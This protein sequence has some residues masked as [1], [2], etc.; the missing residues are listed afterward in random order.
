M[1]GIS[2]RRW[3]PALAFPLLTLW[4]CRGPGARAAAP[5][6]PE[7]S[8]L[9]GDLVAEVDGSPVTRGVLDQRVKNRLA[10]L[11]QEEYEI[12]HQALE[13]LIGDQLLEK[14]AQSRG[15]STAELLKDE[16]DRQVK[17][18]NP[19]D[20]EAVYSQNR[21]RFTGRTKEQAVAE[22]EKALRERELGQR[23][24]AFQAQLRAKAKVLVHLQAPRQEMP[25][26]ASAP[27]LGPPE[28]PVTIVEFTDYQC[29]YCHKAQST[30]DKVLS[31]Y[32]GKVQLVHRDFPLD[33]HS[34]ALPA[35]R[36]ARCAGEQGRFWDYHHNLMTLPGDLSEADLA[37]RAASL[38]LNPGAFSTCLASD[39]YDSSIRESMEAGAQAGVTGTPAYFINGRMIYGARPFEQF[40]EVIDAELHPGG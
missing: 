16:V 2:L 30:I 34:Q 14:E 24:E 32:A 9:P 33:G 39:R 26:S 37:A 15:I 10:R 23:R 28:A 8:P 27:A 38:K 5:A 40:Q 35:A 18:P 21:A 17:G 31:Q 3:G 19:A 1:Q 20:V 4:A 12:R 11:R 6:S 22:I 29:P 7:A 25:V 13:E 36:A